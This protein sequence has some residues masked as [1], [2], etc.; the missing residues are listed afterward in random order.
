M[1]NNQQENLTQELAEIRNNLQ[2]MKMSEQNNNIEIVSINEEVDQ[3]KANTSRLINS[4]DKKME[5]EINEIKSNQ[6]L[7]IQ[8]LASLVMTLAIQVQQAA[9]LIDTWDMMSRS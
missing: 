2:L 4:Q 1:I 5:K 3:V 6:K 9:T 7:D 8:N